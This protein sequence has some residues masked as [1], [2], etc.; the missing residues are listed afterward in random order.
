MRREC[1]DCQL[2]CRLLPVKGINKP[3]NTRCQHQRHGKGCAV[4][5]KPE[6]GFPWECGM[7]NCVWLQNDDAAELRRPDR[8]HYVL[9][10]MPDYVTAQDPKFGEVRIPAVQI[11]CDPKYPDAHRD[12]ELRAW[13]IRRTGFVGLVRFDGEKGLVLIPPYMMESSEWLEKAQGNVVGDH[14]SFAQVLEAL[15]GA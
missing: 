13:L 4:Y 6:K 5:H 8:A 11:W 1:G 9:D 10:I 2:C 7:W 3:S 15:S 12:P 14:H